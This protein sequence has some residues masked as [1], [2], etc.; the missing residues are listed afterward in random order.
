MS[1]YV[2]L[3]SVREQAGFQF[4]ERGEDLSP[5]TGDGSN[6]T[7][8]VP[9][10]KKPIVDKDY[11]GTPVGTPDIVVYANNVEVSVSSIDGDLGQVVLVSAPASGTPM[12]ADWDWSNVEDDLVEE[13]LAE[14]H[15]YIQSRLY[16]KYS[17]PLS[18]TPSLIKL[19]E[20]KLA[21]GLLLDKEY[22]VG[23]DETEDSR[24]RRWIKW[25]EE[26]L[27]EIVSGDLELIDSSNNPLGQR[28]GVGV[29]GWPD[30]ETEDDAEADSG[31]AIRFRVKK[32]F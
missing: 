22:S 9:S 11:S 24:G 15:S 3:Q 18:E 17:L 13:Y 20:K 23:G 25:A 16:E 28:S 6:K 7:F 8:Y 1:Y 29:D 10:G 19:I 14:A 32:D 4:K 21:A 12:T 27:E 31:G 5:S 2:T 30:D 26:K